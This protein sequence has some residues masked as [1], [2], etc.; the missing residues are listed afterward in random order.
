MTTHMSLSIFSMNME[1]GT[2]KSAVYMTVTL[3]CLKFLIGLLAINVYLVVD[4]LV[5][6]VNSCEVY[7]N[8]RGQTMFGSPY[9][10]LPSLSRSS[11]HRIFQHYKR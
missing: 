9:K 4:R 5:E 11:L 2:V 7:D 1:V 10:A 8:V 6:S 3:S